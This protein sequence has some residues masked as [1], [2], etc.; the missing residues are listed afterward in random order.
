[1]KFKQVIIVIVII[2]AIAGAII[3]AYLGFFSSAPST[4]STSASISI[5]N[6]VLPLGT[7]LDFSQVK[8]F[9]PTG[10]QFQYPVVTPPDVG[11]QPL[12]NLIQLNPQ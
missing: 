11:A 5:S 7:T 8:K 6:A 4:P 12:N 9:N 1:M 10:R 3:F 2:A